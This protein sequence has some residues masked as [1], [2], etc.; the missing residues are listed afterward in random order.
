MLV[1]FVH[2]VMNTDNMT[3]SGETIDYGPCAFLD[4]FDPTTVYSSIDHAG[5]YAFGNQPV[6][7]HWNLARLAETLLPLID[8]DQDRAV[9]KAMASLETF[10]PRYDAVWT[11]GMHAKLGLADR[12]GHPPDA[13]VARLVTDWARS[14]TAAASTTPRRTWPWA[15]R[16][17]ATSE[18]VRGLFLDRRQLDAWLSAGSPS[19]RTRT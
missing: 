12:A 5:R 9:E 13:S 7:A 16:R 18:P 17:A 2:G 10:R 6:V 1:G 8:T 15:P 19:N 3:I 11:A 4:A 14:R